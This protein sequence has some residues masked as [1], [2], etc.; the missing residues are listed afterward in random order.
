M[1]EDDTQRV[2]RVLRPDE[3]RQRESHLLGGS[4]S[5]LAVEDHAVTAVQHQHRRAGGLVLALVNLEVRIL[6]I[7]RDLQP[8]AEYGVQDS[9]A[10]I[11]IQHVAKL[12]LLGGAAGLDPG[13]HIPRVMTPEAGLPQGAQ[14]VFE[15]LVPE[16]I[17]GL[18]GELETHLRLIRPSPALA[19]DRFFAL[20][21]S[22]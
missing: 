16:K 2:T 12:I 4:E 22:T 14:K 20:L 13:R 3:V 1:K 8:L 5:I 6:K 15:R 19:A 21:N 17:E 7:Q 11:E 10:H 9:A 18:I